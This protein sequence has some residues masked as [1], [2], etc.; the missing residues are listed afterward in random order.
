M[1]TTLQALPLLGRIIMIGQDTAIRETSK[2]SAS[3]VRFMVKGAT[4]SSI[5]SFSGALLD[6]FPRALPLCSM[7]TSFTQTQQHI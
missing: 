3:S 7:A 5:F 6:I 2:E 4:L 1:E